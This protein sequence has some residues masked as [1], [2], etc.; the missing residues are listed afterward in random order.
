M[1]APL[2]FSL[3]VYGR[4][5]GS[6]DGSAAVVQLACV[7]FHVDAGNAKAFGHTVN[8]NVNMAAEANRL[9]KL[10]NLVV[11]GKVGVKV[12]FTVKFIEFLN[13]AAQCKARTDGKFNNLFVQ[14]RQCARH[15]E[16]HGANMG[17][18]RAAEL[19]GAG[20]EGFGFGF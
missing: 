7:F 8:F 19:S 5:I 3:V 12:V 1:V 10:R 17:V 9:V 15:A 18:R 13:F 14:H 4:E 16:A 20:A 2:W 6:A 11:F